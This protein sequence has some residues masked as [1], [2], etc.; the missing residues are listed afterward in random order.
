MHISEHRGFQ[1]GYSC[2]RRAAN[3]GA[4]ATHFRVSCHRPSRD[5]SY[6]PSGVVAPER[7]GGGLTRRRAVGTRAQLSEAGVVLIT[8][9]STM[10]HVVST[11]PR[12][13]LV[14]TPSELPRHPSQYLLATNRQCP[15]HPRH[16]RDPPAH[17]PS[18][19]PRHPSQYPLAHGPSVPRFG[20]WR[21][22]REAPPLVRPRRDWPY[23]SSVSGQLAW[24]GGGGLVRWVGV[25]TANPPGGI[26]QRLSHRAYI[27]RVSAG[28]AAAVAK[29]KITAQTPDPDPGTYLCHWG[30]QAPARS[31][32]GGAKRCGAQR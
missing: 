30:L 11:P 14:T 8:Y 20:C 27:R 24:L 26:W 17:M 10:A 16:Y 25:L 19:P 21:A 1:V 12:K 5:T 29:N 9:V 13:M 4:S 15:S 3:S 2:P 31:R 32:A 23:E 6:Y 28:R 18:V 22:I 7:G